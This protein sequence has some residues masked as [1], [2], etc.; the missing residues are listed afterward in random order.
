ME[1]IFATGNADKLKEVNFYLTQANVENVFLK[2]VK[3]CHSSIQ[4]KYDPEETGSTFQENAFI[5][6]KALYDLIKAPVFAED[7]GIQVEYLDNE[8]GIYSARLAPTG[9]ERNQILLDRLKDV[10]YEKRNARFFASIC[11]LD[12]DGNQVFFNGKVEG[13]IH[14][15]EEGGGGFGFDPIFYYPALKKTFAQ[16]ET[17]QK[18]KL[19]HRGKALQKFFNYMNAFYGN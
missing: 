4:E 19:S 15:K 9:K 6:A 8:P 14:E 7:S 3:D 13:K 16:L 18:Q 11:F 10:P 1:I 5:K 2:T 17:S 12:I